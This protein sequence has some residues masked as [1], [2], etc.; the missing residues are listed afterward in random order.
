M[1]ETRYKQEELNRYLRKIRIGN[2]SEKQKDKP[3]SY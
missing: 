1:E 2:K 3:G